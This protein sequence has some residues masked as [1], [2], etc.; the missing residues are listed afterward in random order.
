MPPSR[1]GTAQN[2]KPESL[3]GTRAFFL[4]PAQVA[5]SHDRSRA[6]LV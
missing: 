3:Q 6:N 5:D 4:R 1:P 2:K